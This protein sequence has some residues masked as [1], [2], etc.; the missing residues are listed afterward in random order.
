[1]WLTQLRSLEHFHDKTVDLDVNGHTISVKLNII[2]FNTGVNAGAVRI[3]LGALRQWWSVG[4]NIKKLNQL[5][6][7]A[8][9]LLPPRSNEAK[10]IQALL[11]DIKQLTRTPFSYLKVGNQYE[12]AAKIEIL[13]NRLEDLNQ[14]YPHLQHVTAAM[15][16]M[17]AKDRT[18]IAVAVAYT[19][20]EMKNHYGKYPTSKEMQENPELQ[21]KFVHIYVKMLKE[22]GGLDIT[23]MNTDVDGYKVGKEALLYPNATAWKAYPNA[24]E[25]ISGLASTTGS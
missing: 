3:G 12:L 21:N 22:Y 14:K 7:E 6:T 15:N 16:C 25:I 24:Y 20:E 13:S 1:M 8:I 11:N 4:D 19:F 2:S 17:S 23:K 18:G 5:T 9:E 10:E